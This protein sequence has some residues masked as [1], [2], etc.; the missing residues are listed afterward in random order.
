MTKIR[1]LFIEDN[2]DYAQLV[3]FYL[4]HQKD[5]VCEVVWVDHLAKALEFLGKDSTFDIILTDLDLPDSSGIETFSTLRQRRL[6]IP[7]VV[8]T[9]HADERIALK[10]VQDGAQDYLIKG[11][12]QGKMI[13]R[14]LA[15]AV[16]R[17]KMQKE[18]ESLSLTDPLTGLGNRRAFMTLSQQHFKLKERNGKGLLLIMADLDGLKKINDSQGHAAGDQAISAAAQALLAAF[19]RSDVVARIGGDEFAVLA[20]DADENA[21]GIISARLEACLDEMNRSGSLPFRLGMST[22]MVYIGPRDNESLE[23]W[24]EKADQVLYR[25]KAARKAASG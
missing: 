8:S 5:P 11:D 4:N 21:A 14:V 20:V 13:V 25:N 22:G 12:F 7:I 6:G 1:I 16:Q 10:A 3:L 19:R 17:F 2:A 18:L 15:Y 23:A 9:A 24:M